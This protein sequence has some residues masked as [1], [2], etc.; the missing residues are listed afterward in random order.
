MKED[1]NNNC[2]MLIVKVDGDEYSSMVGVFDTEQAARYAA[3]DYMVDIFGVSSSGGITN[4]TIAKPVKIAIVN[5]EKNGIYHGF[6][7]KESEEI[8]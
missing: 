7:F 5:I 4:M 8:E 1:N 2:Y 3:T 6:L